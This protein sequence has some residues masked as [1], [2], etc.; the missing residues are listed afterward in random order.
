[1]LDDPDIIVPL[2]KWAFLGALYAI[3]SVVAFIVMCAGLFFVVKWILGFFTLGR[4]GLMIGSSMLNLDL[5]SKRK[6]YH[7]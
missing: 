4:I 3:G 2:A 5:K 1:M 7:S 6:D